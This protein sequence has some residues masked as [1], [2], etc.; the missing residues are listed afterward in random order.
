MTGTLLTVPDQKERLSLVYVK[1]LAGR[2]GFVTSVPEPD[3]G[4][5]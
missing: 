5:W 1:T 2:V 4:S 3:A